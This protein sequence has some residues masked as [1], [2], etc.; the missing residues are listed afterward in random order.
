[1]KLQIHDPWMQ[2]AAPARSARVGSGR[3]GSVGSGRLGSARVGSGRLG[4]SSASA[5][6]HFAERRRGGLA[7]P[8]KI[9][10]RDDYTKN[11][12]QQV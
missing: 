2:S 9:G 12:K 1:M 10:E 7:L 8:E 5:A 6:P 11:L 4:S 3:L